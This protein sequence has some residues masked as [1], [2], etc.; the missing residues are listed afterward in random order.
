M[1]CLNLGV[2]V[3]AQQRT[4]GRLLTQNIDGTGKTPRA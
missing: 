1:S 3:R 2:A 4:L